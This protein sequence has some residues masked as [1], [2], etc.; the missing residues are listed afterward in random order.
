MSAR[1][2]VALAAVLLALGVAAG[3]FGAHGL[4][5][6]LPGEVLAVFQTA[7]QYHLVHALGLLAVGALRLHWPGSAGLSWAGWLLLAGVLLFSGSLYALAL[8]GARWLGAVTPLGG[9]AF[10]AGWLALAWA[11]LQSRER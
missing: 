10:I 5:G 11:G 2:A 1:L 6:R 9:M 8:T 3:A 4:R 7:V